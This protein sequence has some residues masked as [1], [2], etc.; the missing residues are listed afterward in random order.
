MQRLGRQYPHVGHGPRF[1]Q[2]L[3]SERPQPYYSYGNGAAMRVS[4]CAVSYQKNAEEILSQHP[5]AW[6]HTEFGEWVQGY[7]CQQYA[8]E[9][10]RLIAMVNHLTQS[11]SPDQIRHLIAIF[12][13]CSRYELAF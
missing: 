4:P 8:Q 11:Y 7:G 1:K 6:T 10:D 3:T 2:W 13:A 12:V 9:N 5:E